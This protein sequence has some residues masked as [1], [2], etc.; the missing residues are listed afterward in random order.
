MVSLFYRAWAVNQMPA[1]F[2]RSM[3][4]AGIDAGNLKHDQRQDALLEDEDK[5]AS[6]IGALFGVGMESLR[7]RDPVPDLSKLYFA[8]RLAAC[9]P[10]PEGL[11]SILS[12]FFEVPVEIEEFAG[13]W[14]DLPKDYFC[15]L[16]GSPG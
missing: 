4:A 11:R 12:D 15:R 9:A 2:D 10:G 1:S 3:A 6:Y 8:G 16:G 5:Y 7:L 14:M 13:H